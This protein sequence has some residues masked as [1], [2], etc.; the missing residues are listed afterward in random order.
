MNYSYLFVSAME[1]SE[2]GYLNEILLLLILF[3]KIL[4]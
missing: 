1:N 3:K 4:L 2:S